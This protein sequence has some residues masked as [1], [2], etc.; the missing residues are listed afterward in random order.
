MG[1]L[2]IA[3]GARRLSTR[4]PLWLGLTASAL[5]DL[6]HAF[7]GF[8]PWSRWIIHH[9]HT[10]AGI[11]VLSVAMGLFAGLLVRSASGMFLAAALVV[12]HLVADWIATSVL[13]WSGGPTISFGLHLYQHP[14]ADF[15]IESLVIAVGVYL[16]RQSF[17][18]NRL[19]HTRPA[20]VMLV[21][22]VGF[23]AIWDGMLLSS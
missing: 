6:V 12:S 1:H 2:G 17:G 11:G 10:L 4:L 20:I 16:Y 23:Q 22:L 7:G 9:S 15:L 5:P 13:A 19:K 14:L 18:L 21:V 8:T 3:L